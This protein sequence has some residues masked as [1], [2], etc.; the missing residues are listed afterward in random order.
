MLN[1]CEYC[2]TPGKAQVTAMTSVICTISSPFGLLQLW[3]SQIMY[4]DWQILQFAST[5]PLGFISDHTL[6]WRTLSIGSEPWPRD[7]NH[8]V[9]QGKASGSLLGIDWWNVPVSESDPPS[10]RIPCFNYP[11]YSEHFPWN[12]QL[13]ANTE[14][15]VS[16]LCGLLTRPITVK[17]NKAVTKAEKA[18]DYPAMLSPVFSN[19]ASVDISKNA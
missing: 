4:S 14:A 19:A 6:A 11:Q 9:K 15:T 18:N 3:H 12:R 8:F 2:S 16:I 13:P 17:A 7:A 10:H 1:Y 5:Q